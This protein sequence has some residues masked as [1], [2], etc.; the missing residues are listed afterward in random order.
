M[1]ERTFIKETSA[2]CPS[3]RED[4]GLIDDIGGLTEGLEAINQSRIDADSTLDTGELYLI[5]TKIFR[6][7][8]RQNEKGLQGTPYEPKSSGSIQFFLDEEKEYRKD[9]VDQRHVLTEDSQDCKDETQ[10]PIQK[11]AIASISTTRTVDMVELGIKSIVYRNV[12]GQ[13]NVTQ[14]TYKNIANDFAKE[15]QGFQL[16]TVN[17]YYDRVSLFRLEV[18]R[19]NGNWIDLLEK[20]FSPCMARTAALIQHH[21]N[22]SPRKR[23]LRIQVYSRLR[24]CLDRKQQLQGEICSSLRKSV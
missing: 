5:G 11:V 1:S 22:Q 17:S 15:G 8:E 12:N 4:D 7:V 14:F 9:W 13:P 16:G 21:S 24:K 18:K 2:S 19:G 20:K 3:S 6:C 23:F 10:L